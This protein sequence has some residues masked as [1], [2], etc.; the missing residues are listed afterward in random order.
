MLF[1]L[2]D[3]QTSARVSRLWELSGR[4]LA[5]AGVCMGAEQLVMSDN[6]LLSQCA[7]HMDRTG[8]GT[9]LRAHVGTWSRICS[10]L[11]WE[12]NREEFLP[13]PDEIILLLFT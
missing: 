3:S 6:A 8:S 12:L 5:H 2:A 1:L 4:S 13:F 9:Q 7:T 10:C 11:K